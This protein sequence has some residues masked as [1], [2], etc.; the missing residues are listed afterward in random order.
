LV[1]F[2][3]LLCFQHSD[4]IDAA[5]MHLLVNH[6]REGVQNRLVSSLY[7]DSL[8]ENLL[9]ED[10]GLTNERARVKALLDAY[11][12]AFKVRRE[13]FAFFLCGRAD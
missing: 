4:T 10:E 8:F 6:V 5:V 13:L 9:Q 7:R 3:S 1:S 11:R 12:E 2:A